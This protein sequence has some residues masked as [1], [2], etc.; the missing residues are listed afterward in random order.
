MYSDNSC[1]SSLATFAPF[2][3]C[4]NT[5]IGSYS[6]DCRGNGSYTGNYTTIYPSSGETSKPSTT[7]PTTLTSTTES[8]PLTPTISSSSSLAASLLSQ[9]SSASSTDATLPSSSPSQAPKQGDS[10]GALIRLGRVGLGASLGSLLAICVVVIYLY[11]IKRAP[12]PG[13][14]NGDAYAYGPNQQGSHIRNPETARLRN[15]NIHQSDQ[16]LSANSSFF[17]LPVEPHPGR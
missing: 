12:Q 11:K 7:P 17:S 3:K 5:T 16:F 13:S 6:V 8:N 9:S 4:T 10:N 14:P 2:G 15:G 1:G